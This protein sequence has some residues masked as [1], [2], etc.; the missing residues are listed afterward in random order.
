MNKSTA[1]HFDELRLALRRLFF[2]IT[3]V[4]KIK[5]ICIWLTKQI[6]KI[7]KESK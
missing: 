2:Q 4:L 7:G 1:E 3:I 6:L 5:E